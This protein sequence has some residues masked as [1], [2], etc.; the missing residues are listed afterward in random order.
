MK[1]KVGCVKRITNTIGKYCKDIKDYGSFS[2]CAKLLILLLTLIFLADILN[3]PT[4][5][6]IDYSLLTL[7][8]VCTCAFVLVFLILIVDNHM[9]DLLK[10][11]N[12]NEVDSAI[13]LLLFS[14]FVYMGALVAIDKSSFYKW[15]ILLIF[16]LIL[17]TCLC[18]R[19]LK[20][21]RKISTS[22]NNNI[23]DIKDL[24]DETVSHNNKLP[25]LL[26]EKD[27]SYDLLDRK[28]IINQL[29]ESIQACKNYD[30]T[31]VIG[32]EGAWGSGKTTIVNNV[33]EELHRSEDNS[34]IIIDAI[35]PWIYNSQ[36]ALL[37]AL[38]D[39][40]L[41]K[42]GLKYDKS[43]IKKFS[44]TLI[45]SIMGKETIGNVTSN[46]LLSDTDKPS[47]SSIKLQIGN[48][49]QKNNK[50]IVV[51]VDNIDRA[52][53][54]NIVF[55]FKI[56]S[57]IFDLKRTVY[58]L[59]YD[60]KRIEKILKN[61]LDI[62]EHFIEKIV[63][64]EIKVSSISK[65]KMYTLVRDSMT[66]I[67]S[68]YGVEETEISDFNSIFKFL[69][70]TIKDVRE[71]KRAI[72]STIPLLFKNELLY[73]PDL[74]TIMLIRFY[75]EDLYYT[76]KDNLHFFISV[77]LD[78]N[79]ELYRLNISVYRDKFNKEGKKFYDD[80]KES[81]GEEVLKLLSNVFP[82][83]K[84]YLDNLELK[85]EYSNY[86]ESYADINRN[87]RM[88]S[89]K[90]FDLYFSFCENEFTKISTIYNKFIDLIKNKLINND[91]ENIPEDF[92]LLFSGVPTYYHNEIIKVMWCEKDKIEDKLIYP[93]L[94]G[95]IKSSLTISRETGFLSLSAF[96]RSCSIMATLYLKIDEKQKCAVV[97][98]FRE[99][100]KLLET[101]YDLIYW[102]NSSKAKSDSQN[103]GVKTLES[104]CVEL[105]ETIISKPINIFEDD[106]Y[107][108][109]I[110]RVLLNIKRKFL[111]QGKTKN[112]EIVDYI[113]KV[114]K[115]EFVYKLIKEMVSYSEGSIGY[116]YYISKSLVESYVKDI[117][118]I[119]KAIEENLPKNEK[120][121]FLKELYTDYL[122]ES[123]HPLNDEGYISEHKIE[124]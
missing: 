85:S 34:F 124:F 87:C 119:N 106:N 42:S 5:I 39:E 103:D 122:V 110:S 30:G 108:P 92:I 116:V 69:A 12:V 75:Y 83:T 96:Q 74:L 58:I 62:D 104:L 93:S 105:Y 117:S 97:E 113:E 89:A 23:I 63:Q 82:Y 22:E 90:Y 79:I 27:V 11:N 51:F 120:E 72:N 60:R 36:E 28:V 78:Q 7:I 65:D 45:A 80:L 121:A 32:L 95:L 35:D 50:T 67:L 99:N 88:S 123:D 70:N 6:I 10:T 1:E 24:L 115:S 25:I 19:I 86:D 13:V 73:K 52:S 84:K 68:L 76:I 15:A 37:V 18:I 102:I 59:S 8:T 47:I 4:L 44:K 53:G 118:I 41:R 77:D 38:F 94:I 54:E 31:F 56:I 49:L 111:H 61:N 114:F 20:T 112:V 64:Q 55:L 14:A 46:V 109:N 3:L 57:I 107:F 66:N 9:L 26:A 43:M 17:F 21:Q 40:V 48:Y 71:L 100:L 98:L 29:K 91:I 33:I 2:K 101:L 16:S 81:Y